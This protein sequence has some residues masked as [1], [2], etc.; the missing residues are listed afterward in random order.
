MDDMDEVSG[1]VKLIDLVEECVEVYFWDVD[2]RSGRHLWFEFEGKWGSYY[3]FDVVA[4]ESNDRLCITCSL[5]M[6]IAARNN[7]R[8]LG[9][10]QELFRLIHHDEHSLGT[11]SCSKPDL[12]NIVVQW[13]YQIPFGMADD[14]AEVGQ[15][16]LD[17]TAEVDRYYDQL[18]TVL[19]SNDDA[20]ETLDTAAPEIFGTA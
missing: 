14:H 13:S 6:K 10:L 4:K 7:K 20:Q 17:A 8:A 15:L 1:G 12:G 3:S 5:P 18:R 19:V 9:R 2:R 11:F 16:L